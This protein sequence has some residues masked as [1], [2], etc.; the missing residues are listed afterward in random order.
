MRVIKDS[1]AI[2]GDTIVSMINKSLNSGIVPSAI[3]KLAK[4]LNSADCRPINM[5]PVVEKILEIVVKTNCHKTSKTT[6]S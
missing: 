2:V 5:L 1:F 4:S 6:T 3:Q